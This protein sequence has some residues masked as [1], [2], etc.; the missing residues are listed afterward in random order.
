[1]TTTRPPELV[2]EH[3]RVHRWRAIASTIVAA[4]VGLRLVSGTDAGW[5]D[6]AALVVSSLVAL[7]ASGALWRL[8]RFRQQPPCGTS[9]DR[10]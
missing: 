8:R 2:G 9:S 3:E 7:H 6:W 10:R 4:V 5:V 1:M